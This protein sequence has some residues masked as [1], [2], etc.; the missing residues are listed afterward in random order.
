VFTTLL[1]LPLAPLRAVVWI[2]RTL[3]DEAYRQWTDPATVRL[4]LERTQQR[5][6]AGEI[7]DDERAAAEDELLQRLI[8]GRAAEGVGS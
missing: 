7:T 5:W 1:T 4:E 6:E 8:P 3:A 2:G